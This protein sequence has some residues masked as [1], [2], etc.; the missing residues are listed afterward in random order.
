MVDE[1]TKAELQAMIDVQEKAATQMEKVVGSLNLIVDNQKSILLS[2]TA[3]ASILTNCS[4][5]KERVKTMREDV[6]LIKWVVSAIA[7]VVAIGYLI[8]KLIGH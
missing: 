2:L 5:C 8:L 7:G 1:I 3:I 6:T 4:E